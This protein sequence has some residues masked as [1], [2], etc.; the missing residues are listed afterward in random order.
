MLPI[1]MRFS[2]GVCGKSFILDENRVSANLAG[3]P[4]FLTHFRKDRGTS[5]AKAA[6]KKPS[7]KVNPSKASKSGG[8]AVK[9]MP[10]AKG[11][12]A[13]K[14]AKPRLQAKP[15]ARPA[16]KVAK[17][18]GKAE[19]RI[20]G[21]P[22]KAKS[23]NGSMPKPA[24]KAVVSPPARLSAPAKGVKRPTNPVLLKAPVRPT[25]LT[26]SKPVASPSLTR[27]NPGI[28]A[29]ANGSS[30]LMGKTSV[31]PIAN[32]GVV[33]EDKAERKVEKPMKK[34]KDAERKGIAVPAPVPTDTKPS[35]NVAGL[36]AAEL[37]HYRDMLLAKRREL[38]GDM[39][40]MENEALQRN[41]NS[42]LSN[43]PLHMADMGTDNYEQEFTLGLMEKDRN[44]LREINNALA[45]IQ[46]GTYGICEGTQAAIGKPRL[47][48]QPWARFSIEHARKLEQRM[49]R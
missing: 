18:S 43:L 47:E 21:K 42:N 48:A 26:S 22:S 28:D 6:K 29:K 7:V 38:V 27:T 5:V 30:R 33:V 39:H 44:L 3:L 10:N 40:S 15:L 9:A 31:K 13:A 12:A 23:Q 45:K 20:S 36:R 49:G 14:K 17:K 35:K 34:S 25:A 16:P 8:K 41:G 32:L 2:R 24:A 46:D 1:P 37:E 4:C 19:A 11:K